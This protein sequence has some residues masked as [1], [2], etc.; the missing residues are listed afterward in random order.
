MVARTWRAPCRSISSIDGAAGGQRRL[1]RAA[2]GAVAGRAGAP[3]PTRAARPRRPSRRTGVVDEPV[4]H[5]VDLARRGGAGGRR[6]RDPHLGVAVA[7]LGGDGAL[8]DRGGSGQDDQPRRAD[9]GR[10]VGGLVT[11]GRAR[12]R[13]RARRSAWCRGRARGGDS[14][15]PRRSITWRARTL[16]RPG[17]DCSRSTT[18]ILPMTS[19]AWPSAST[20]MIEAPEFLSRFFTSARSRREAAALSSAAWRCSGVN[21]GRATCVRSFGRVR[22][23]EGPLAGQS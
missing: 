10:R 9:G 12:T 21:G 15:M 18:R 8:A 16:P 17:I 3:P 19:L 22:R 6:D 14:A 11:A 23:R 7:H 2:R 13:A 5:A 1:D 4:V 20:S